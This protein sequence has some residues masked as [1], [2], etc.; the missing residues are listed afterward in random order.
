M[1]AAADLIV[2]AAV[3]HAGKS[4]FDN[5]PERG[6]IWPGLAL[7]EQFDDR[8]VGE[9]RSVAEAAV[10]LIE[11]ADR[12]FDNFFDYAGVEFT[13]R[14]VEYLGFGNSLRKRLRC[15]VYVRPFFFKRFGN[16]EEDALEAGAA[17]SVVG[18]EV[19]PSEERLT[20]RGEE[21]GEG[22]A[23]LSGDGADGGLIA[24]VD[25]GAL[26]AVNLYG[27]VELVDEGGDFGVLVALPVDHVAP[28]APNRADVEEDR[29]LLR[30]GLVEGG[31]APF[32]PVDWLVR[33]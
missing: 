20:V 4:L 17:V 21:G 23:A 2:K 13:P 1:E 11:L 29:L 7:E 9:F 24:G 6:A 31:F 19:C 12:G 14:P 26:V 32:V 5:G 18:G 30:P 3:G 33:R 8:G 27:D 28:V 22:P 10:G 16:R 25:V 15:F